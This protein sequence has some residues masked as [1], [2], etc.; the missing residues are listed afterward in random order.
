MKRYIL[1]AGKNYYPNGGMHD[2]VDSFDTATEAAKKYNNGADRIYQ[3][4]HIYDTQKSSIIFDS[5]E[6]ALTGGELI[7]RAKK[8]DARK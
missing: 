1:F 3:W 5:E 8:I 7:K 4:Y 2:F 6:T